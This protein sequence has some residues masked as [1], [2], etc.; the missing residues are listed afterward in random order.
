M[1]NERLCKLY[2]KKCIY[3]NKSYFVCQ[4]FLLHSAHTNGTNYYISGNILYC[5]RANDDNN[6]CYIIQQPLYAHVHNMYSKYNTNTYQYFIIGAFRS[7]AVSNNL[8]YTIFLFRR[9]TYKT[10]PQGITMM[11]AMVIKITVLVRVVNAVNPRVR[12]FRS[13][14]KRDRCIRDTT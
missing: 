13:H 1:C 8:Y 10:I 9:R 7:V 2:K 6:V 14:A 12:G 5:L 4:V 3:Q 11:V